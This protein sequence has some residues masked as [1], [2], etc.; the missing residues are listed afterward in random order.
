MSL[1]AV[2]PFIIAV[3]QVASSGHS[4]PPGQEGQTG[5]LLAAF[6]TT[7]LIILLLWLL[8]ALVFVW[9]LASRGK[10]IG[11]AIFGLRLVSTADGHP[12]GWGNALLWYA[13]VIVGSAL[14]GGILGILFLL[15][16]LFDNESGW[17]QAWQDKMVSAV[18][19]NHRMGR[20]TLTR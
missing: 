3:I 15:S 17:N 14:T 4:G 9:W 19:I 2:V 1:L 12:I 18:L 10:S 11:N 6:S 20:D 16:P 13:V 7:A 5:V 8:I